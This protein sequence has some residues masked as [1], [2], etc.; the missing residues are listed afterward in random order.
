MELSV[1]GQSSGPVQPESN[2]ALG[3]PSLNVSPDPGASEKVEGILV[4]DP[5]SP[6]GG[7]VD[8]QV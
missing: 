6:K 7:I 2:S 3:S 1:L 4:S 5:I 8:A